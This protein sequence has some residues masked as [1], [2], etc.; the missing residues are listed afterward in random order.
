MQATRY[1]QLKKPPIDH[2]L[3]NTPIYNMIRFWGRKPYNLV[4]RYIEH[5]TKEG[6]VVLD[7]FAG[8]GVV[9][10]EALKARRRVI[11]NDLNAYCRFIARVSSKPLETNRL[12]DIFG[13]LL[14]S[15]HVETYPV[16]V[17]GKRRRI[18]FDWLYS[19]KCSRCSGPAEIIA[20]TY[21]RI[22]EPMRGLRLK[23]LPLKGKKKVGIPHQL[24]EKNG[25][26]ARIAIEVWRIINAHG[27]VSHKDLTKQLKL[28]VRPEEITRA[29]N[30]KLAE[31]GLI[32][33][34]GETPIL[35]EY[36]CHSGNCKAKRYNKSPDKDDLAKME[37]I[38]QMKPVY[39][40][41]TDKLSYPSSNRFLTLR[42][43]TESIDRLFTERNL[44]ALSI[45]RHEIDGLDVG[46]EIKQ[47]LLLCFIAILEHVCK[48]ERP[49]KKG[50]GVKNYIIHPIFLEQNVLHALCNRFDSIVAG[51]DEANKEIGEFH[52]ESSTPKEVVNRKANI[53]LLNLDSR[54]LPLED[55]CIDYVFTDPEYGDS[56]QY[57][58][59]SLMGSAWLNLK[60]DWKDEIVVNA[61][62]AK[63]LEIYREMLGEAFR[64]TY[65]VLRP[66]KY[67]TVTFHSREI[68]YWNALMCVIQTAGFKYVT[69]IY[70]IPQRE[71]T[72]WLYARNPGE[73]N[74][75]VYVTFYKSEIRA[76]LETKD[77]NVKN[78]IQHTILPEAHQIILLHNE[79]AT[80]NQL[81]RGITLCLID[82]GLMHNP[83]IRDLNYEKIF[84]EHFERLGR[85]KVWRLREEERTSPID[86]IPLDRRI[87]WIIFS[88]FNR[89]HAEGRRVTISDILS[90]IF[91]SLKNAKTPEN[92]E[93]LGILKQIAE[94]RQKRGVPFW[95]FKPPPQLTLK[96]IPPRISTPKIKL[97]ERLDH[98][99]II[100]VISRFGSGFG[101]DVWVGD[102]E[103]RKNPELTK[104]RTIKKLEIAGLDRLVL[105]R[106]RNVDVIWLQRKNIPVSLIEV[107]HTTDPRMG[108]LR[109]ANIFEAV[110]HLNVKTI[111][112]LPDKKVSQLGD[113][114][115]EPSIKS[116]IG[117]KTVNYA[118][119]SLI[120]E[121][122]DEAEYH[123][124]VFKD[125]I[126]I[127]SVLEP[128]ASPMTR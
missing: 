59:L 126:N 70:Q 119:Y 99:R 86:F 107:E 56:I 19:T 3:P 81:V 85:G 87:E 62:Q 23:L 55:S 63:T 105:N 117:E 51:K 61:K 5:Y 120:A 123:K 25:K 22:Y 58:E 64:E 41:P 31:Q 34:A 94:P 91:T 118:T 33:V 14:Q 102:P 47:S 106:L 104:C 48:M 13:E 101:F 114:V 109:M 38:N 108:L 73:M 88:V 43:G 40:Y 11:Y 39:Y 67:M 76:S 6:D 1:I 125:F 45:I 84:D 122:A 83:K 128:F 17:D 2:A 72:N 89:K 97:S 36:E 32:K 35:I 52:K 93:I 111:T 90:S 116:L 8:C 115:K 96:F 10:I 29:I 16:S 75:D 26:L 18:T 60:N 80:F 44:I 24:L 112:V 71:Y 27:P 110:P 65:R 66:S 9:A 42:P 121:L 20:V 15:I 69:A 21:T 98:D 49:N 103:V 57:Y 4:R 28:D 77:I 78:V 7:P 74:G 100:S 46:D 53:C 127:C 50:W 30:Q 12:R 92:T 68:K 113:I 95:Q 37:Q 124:L 82:R 79:Q 54:N